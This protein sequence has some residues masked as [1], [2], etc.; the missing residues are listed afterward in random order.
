MI[1]LVANLDL[2]FLDHSS[3]AGRN[4][5]RSLVGLDGHE[6]LINR[7]GITGLDQQLDH[8]HILE[9]TNIGNLDIHN[10]HDSSLPYRMMRR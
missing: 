10:C 2:D 6:R 7:H 3:V 8:A 1:D 5:H 9:V 4:L